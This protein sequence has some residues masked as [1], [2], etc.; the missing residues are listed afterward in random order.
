[1]ST[2]Y[3][4][5]DVLE[6]LQV[7]GAPNRRISSPMATF[8]QAKAYADGV[9]ESRNPAIVME[10]EALQQTV[11]TVAAQSVPYVRGSETSEQA[12]TEALPSA[13]TLRE[14]VYNYINEN[15][16]ATDEEIQL[17]LDMNPS[18]ERPR[19]IELVRA[20]RVYNSELTRKTRAGRHAAVWIV[21][22]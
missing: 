5:Y 6:G 16:G 4:L 9:H 7:P 17:A 21:R 20:G 18:T 11:R 8:T 15:G 14:Q 19:R 22:L 1:M 12:A 13:A 10:V 2:Y 3:V